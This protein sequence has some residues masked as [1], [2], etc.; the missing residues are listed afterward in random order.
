MNRKYLYAVA[1]I[2]AFLVIWMYLPRPNGEKLFR[3]TGVMIVSDAGQPVGGFE[4]VGQYNISIE[5]SGGD[6]ELIIKL[7][8]GLG[9]PLQKHRFKILDIEYSGDDVKIRLENGMLI[10][11]YINI[12]SIWSIYNGTYTAIYSPN[13]TSYSVGY[14]S[15]NIFPGF[16]EHY[17]IEIHLKPS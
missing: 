7:N 16:L 3:F 5:Y 1:F 9:D 14:I 4:W 17:Y 11:K 13:D 15:L 6:G 8:R 10:L 12:D 2:L